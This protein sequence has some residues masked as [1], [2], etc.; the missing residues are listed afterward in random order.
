MI[1][2]KLDESLALAEENNKLV[3]ELLS[4][5]A[6][7]LGGHASQERSIHIPSAVTASN[8]TAASSINDTVSEQQIESRLSQYSV[9]P[10][11]MNTDDDDKENVSVQTNNI[12]KEENAGLKEKLAAALQAHASTVVEKEQ[13]VR[14]FQTIISPTRK[15]PEDVVPTPARQTA[16]EKRAETQSIN[17]SKT[18]RVMMLRSQSCLQS[19]RG[20]TL[21]R[22]Q[23]RL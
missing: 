11:S 23:R 5:R 10:P 9:I 18:G 13:V 19:E 16:R 21:R 14:R 1:T 22:S 4:K 15:R 12:L 17:N 8:V 6:G 2:N 20:P 3:K 7:E